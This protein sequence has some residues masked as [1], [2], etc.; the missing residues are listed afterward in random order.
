MTCFVGNSVAGAEM[1]ETILW[2]GKV[3]TTFGEILGI[4]G[5][6]KRSIKLM[7]WSTG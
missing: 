7:H 3:G 4:L 1:A 6:L 2:M 5:A